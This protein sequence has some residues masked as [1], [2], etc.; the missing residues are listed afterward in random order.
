MQRHQ[1]SPARQTRI[2]A[3][4]GKSPEPTFATFLEKLCEVG[5]DVLRLN[6][7]HCDAGYLKE[8]AILDWANQPTVPGCA[9]RVAVM[10]DLQG[11]KV[12]IGRV[13][14]E[15]LT[16][17]EGATVVLLPEGAPYQPADQMQPDGLAAVVIPVPGPT[18]S[19]LVQG[20]RE[21]WRQRPD[22]RPAILFG[23]GD[24]I[25]EATG[26]GP[27]HLEA[28]VVAGGTL[29][30]KKGLTVRELDLDLDPF[31]PKDQLDLRFCLEQ[32]VDYV[33]LS[34]VRTPRD[35]QRVRAFMADQVLDSDPLSTR[36]LPRLI[37]KIETISAVEN[38]DALLDACDGVM[39]ARGDLGLQLGF[40]AVPGV[41][42]RLVIAA[43][44]QG[45]PCIIATQML[46]SMIG[47]PVPTRA[48]AAD[49]FNAILDGGDAVMLSGET[50]VGTRP[51]LVV[52]TMDGI[53]RQAES[54]R[55]E[56]RANRAPMRLPPIG[57]ATHIERINGEFAHMAARLAEQLPAFAIACFTRS[58]LT[59]ERISRFRPAAPV[60]AFC[61]T[62]GVARRCL[63]YWG[64]HPVV[65]PGFDT[66]RDRLGTMVGMARE[67]LQK[68]YGMKRGDPLVVTAGVDW[69][70]GGTN[71]LQVRIEDHTE[72]AIDLE[73]EGGSLP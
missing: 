19:A 9:P 20:L 25:V 34:F 36:P 1:G 33:A 22:A 71:T 68:R 10:A 44:K 30:S 26:M 43:R 2:V 24:L 42:K 57:P 16:L 56:D 41:Q 52:E 35:L 64:V 61:A 17:I 38:I 21:L 58:G 12:R 55:I 5:V 14:A 51:Y 70:S 31:P 54:Y 13:A 23:D 72:A 40:E 8:K 49:V 45:K 69:P 62:D 66:R 47:N 63:L 4:I 59:P 73:F 28:R 27:H 65:L 53:V 7:S 48:E 60:L 50:S 39:V 15:G 11:P 32:G 3:T 18:G 6:M 29:F 37:A 67:I 46:E